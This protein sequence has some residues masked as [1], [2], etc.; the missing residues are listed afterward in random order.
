VDLARDGNRLLAHRIRSTAGCRPRS[1]VG[2]GRLHANGTPWGTP[3]LCACAAL[4]ASRRSALGVGLYAARRP[5]ARRP[6]H[7]GPGRA[8]LCGL[9]CARCPPGVAHHGATRGMIAWLDGTIPYLK[10]IH[11]AAL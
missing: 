10:A 2:P 1:T 11:I 6:Y 4:C 7:V 5:T 8:P 3:N 9:G